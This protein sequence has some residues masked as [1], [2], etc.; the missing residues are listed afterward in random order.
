MALSGS[1]QDVPVTDLLQFIH[2]GVRSGTLSLE[3]LAGRAEIAFHRGRIVSACSGGGQRLGELLLAAGAVE[4]EALADALRAQQE[5]VPRRA[6]GQVLL[7]REAMTPQDLSNVLT[8]HV[9]RVVGGVLGWRQGQ[10][11]FDPDEVTLI[12]GLAMSPA[13]L[14]PQLAVDTQMVL[15]DALR[16]FDEKNRDSVDE[17]SP[18]TADEPRRRTTVPVPRLER[19]PVVHL[20]SPDPTFAA[21]LVAAIDEQGLFATR[22]PL[23]DAGVTRPR[24]P[25]PIVVLD[26]R[27][28]GPALATLAGLRQRRCRSCLLCVVEPRDVPRAYELGADAVLGGD[29]VAVA[30]CARALTRRPTAHAR[31]EAIERR[32]FARLRRVLDELRTG[33]V[34]ATISLQIMSIVS[35]RFERAVLF[36]VRPASLVALG[37]FGETLTGTPLAIATQGLTVAREE[38]GVLR[39]ATQEGRAISV[40]FERAP[41]PRA[42]VDLLGRPMTRQCVAFPIVGTREVIAV[43]YADNG[44]REQAIDELDVLELATAQV[45]VVFENEVLRRRLVQREQA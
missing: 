15:L 4:P 24:E 1:L 22:V 16:L 34:S 21:T 30:A 27:L 44:A 35:E 14:L 43:I 19:L 42:L 41:L 40:D 28:D 18:A 17:P 20:V 6:L 2:V 39:E 10:F 12:D 5:E 32:G 13:E 26:A 29:P 45:G 3:G 23:R 33:L 7:A 25:A 36:M 8:E 37:A 9:R 11:T 31:D 38:A